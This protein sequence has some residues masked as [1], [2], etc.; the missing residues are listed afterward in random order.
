MH[1][2][3]CLTILS[4]VT[5]LA[6]ANAQ[7]FEFHSVGFVVPAAIN[8]EGTIA[9]SF[10]CSYSA[11]FDG[12]QANFHAF[13]L[14]HKGPGNEVFKVAEPDVSLDSFA[15]GIDADGNVVGGFCPRPESCSVDNAMHGY[16]FSVSF[17]SVSQIDVPGA[18]ATLAGG[19]NKA[20]AIVGMACKAVTCSLA[21]AADAQ[22]FLLD[23][24]GG[25]FSMISFPG[26]LGTAATGINDSGEIVGNYL[27]CK[28]EGSHASGAPCTFAQSHG[29]QLIGG[30]Y[31]TLDP[32]G[33][34][35]TNVGG[36]NNSGAV[37]GTYADGSNKTHGFLFSNGVFSNIDFPGATATEVTGI[38][39][40]GQI[41][42]SAQV[43]E[44]T[45]NFMAT[46]K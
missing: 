20:G 43:G 3:I 10:C 30:V 21:Y 26:V 8:S 2:P 38:N 4:L 11:G 46:P 23:H 14:R 7:T 41:V 6:A 36:I 5:A 13:L 28:T 18:R 9:G 22:G 12:S 32:P 39:D 45:E 33:S 25:S 37:V 42:G 34:V 31:T 24:I 29:F 44:G 1:K 27:A 15:T 16:L 35:A 40:Q 19:I 17:N